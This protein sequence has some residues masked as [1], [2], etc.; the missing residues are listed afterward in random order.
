M[1]ESQ[2]V[3]HQPIREEMSERSELS[4]ELSEI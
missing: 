4:Q 1:F 3:Y 2:D